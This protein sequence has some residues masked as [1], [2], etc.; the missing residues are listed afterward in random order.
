[1]GKKEELKLKQELQEEELLEKHSY[2]NYT[3]LID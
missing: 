2:K 3:N 1:M